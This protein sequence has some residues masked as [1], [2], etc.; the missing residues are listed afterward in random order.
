[1]CRPPDKGYVDPAN[2]STYINKYSV[3]DIMEY[4]YAPAGTHPF[5]MHVNPVQIYVFQPSASYG[6]W[7]KVGDWHDVLRLPFG[8]GQAKVRFQADRFDGNIVMHCHILRHEDLGLMG[9]SIIGNKTEP[10]RLGEY[11]PAYTHGAV[12]GSL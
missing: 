3:G 9:V 12:A 7:W 1:M 4:T 6:N 10:R 2:A 5:H 11:S 8:G